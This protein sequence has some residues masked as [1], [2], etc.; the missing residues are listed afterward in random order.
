MAKKPANP[1]DPGQ[2]EARVLTSC[3]W[4]ETDDIVILTNEE[5][6]LAVEAGVVDTHPD[7]VAY[8]KSLT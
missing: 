6:L 5:A 1:P 2:I 4:G 8:A 3:A 7:A